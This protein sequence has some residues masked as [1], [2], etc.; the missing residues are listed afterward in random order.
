MS[1]AVIVAYAVATLFAALTA[2]PAAALSSGG[3]IASR[4]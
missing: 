1:F 2:I 4:D 3:S